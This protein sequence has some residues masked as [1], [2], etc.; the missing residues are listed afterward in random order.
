MVFRA[1]K[2]VGRAATGCAILSHVEQDLLV[3]NGVR[4]VVR[5]ARFASVHV[6][7]GHHVGSVH[8]SMFQKRRVIILAG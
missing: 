1:A 3:N 8:T 4:I 6:P 2:V 7:A 5:P